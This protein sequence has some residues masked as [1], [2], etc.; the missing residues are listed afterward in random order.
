MRKTL[1][2]TLILA[3]LVL[4]SIS[5]QAQELGLRFGHIN[6]NNVALDGIFSTGEFS[7]VHANVSFGQKVWAWMRSGIRFTT[8][9]QTPSSS[10][11]LALV[12]RSTYPRTSDLGARERLV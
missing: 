4:G 1:F 12:L 7:R 10:G 11:M 5:A 8:I 2:F 3:G 6:G 9:S